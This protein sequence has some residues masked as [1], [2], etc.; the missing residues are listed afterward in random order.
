MVNEGGKRREGLD[1]PTD[2]EEVT[3]RFYLVLAAV[4]ATA[5]ILSFAALGDV[6]RIG[7]RSTVDIRYASPTF[8][9]RNFD[10]MLSIHYSVLMLY[11]IEPTV[12][13]VV[14]IVSHCIFP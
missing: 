9:Y 6:R 11:R 2:R 10:G 7:I 8:I 12:D 4:L 1:G 3:A 14:R 5:P 13:M